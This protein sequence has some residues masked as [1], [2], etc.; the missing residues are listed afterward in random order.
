MG[1]GFCKSFIIFLGLAI[2]MWWYTNNYWNGVVL[3]VIYAIVKIIWNVL[4]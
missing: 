4:R 1:L 3:L 2:A